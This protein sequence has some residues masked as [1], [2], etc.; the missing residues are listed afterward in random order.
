MVL[1]LA[2][3]AGTAILWGIY[4]MILYPAYF[5]PF[6]NIPTPAVSETQP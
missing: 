2:V 5:T 4:W 6:P 3:E 1:L